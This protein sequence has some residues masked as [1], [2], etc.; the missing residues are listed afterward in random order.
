MIDVTLYHLAKNRTREVRYRNARGAL[1]ARRP[2]WIRTNLETP[3]GIAVV[4]DM[5]SDGEAFQV[6]FPWKNEVY[7]GRNQMTELS[8][9]RVENIRPQHILD[10]I[11]L[12]PVDPDSQMLLDV[13]TYGRSGYQVLHEVAPD[14][15]GGLRIRRKFWFGRDNLQLSR[16]MVLDDRTELVTDAW[17]RSWR[18]DN[19]LPYP[20]FIRI[21]RPQDGYTLQIR[22]VRPGLNAE[23][24]DS[25]FELD[26]PD[27]VERKTI[28]AEPENSTEA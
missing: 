25:S 15:H 7:E 8:E 6:H 5:V 13:E 19:G 18:E 1:V 9:N 21:E 24:P 22:I 10:A 17:Y 16:L 2:D 27:D 26:L 23:V 12:Q 3:G 28:G 14:E 4:Y 20:E 11:M